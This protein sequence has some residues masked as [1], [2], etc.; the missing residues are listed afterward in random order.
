MSNLRFWTV[1]DGVADILKKCTKLQSFKTTVACGID[2]SLLVALTQQSGRVALK[3][4]VIRWGHQITAVG[5]RALSTLCGANLQVLDI[6]RSDALAIASIIHALVTCPNLRTF[7]FSCPVTDRAVKGI[8]AQGK[9]LQRLFI[10]SERGKFTDA[11]LLALV[12]G[13]S[14]LRQLQLYSCE[15]VTDKVVATIV[16]QNKRL[17]IERVHY[18]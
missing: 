14:R 11:G 18:F 8:V 5:L 13:C 2:D 3:E 7:L 6:R 16:E 17:A 4:L 12:R 10:V 1:G 9:R 15:R